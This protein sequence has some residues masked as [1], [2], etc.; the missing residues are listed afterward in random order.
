MSQQATPRNV[1]T[2]GSVSMI[3]LETANM[4]NEVE[5]GEEKVNGRKQGVP[6]AESGMDHVET[7]A[8][9]AEKVKDAAKDMAKAEAEM[10]VAKEEGS[11]APA[12]EFGMDHMET[13]AT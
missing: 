13:E 3:L 8:T 4:V 5:T 1:Y 6:V 10:K 11:T 2:P 7:E 9:E 12:A